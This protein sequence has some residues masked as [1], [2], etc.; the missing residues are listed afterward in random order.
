MWKCMNDGVSEA[1]LIDVL[2]GTLADFRDNYHFGYCL[3]VFLTRFSDFSLEQRG[4]PLFGARVPAYLAD[5]AESPRTEPID[6]FCA[7]FV[8]GVDGRPG[9]FAEFVAMFRTFVVGMG[10]VNPAPW[11]K[12]W[13]CAPRSRR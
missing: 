1:K 13:R 3:W 6:R 10:S 2:N 5:F 7:F 4:K 8:D 12:A 9:S 11:R